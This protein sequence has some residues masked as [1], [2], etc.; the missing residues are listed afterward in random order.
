MDTMFWIWLAIILITAIIE[1]CT[2]ELV[3]IWFT[4]GSIP[5]MILCATTDIAIAWQIVIGIIL[6]AILIASFRKLSI[7]FLFR[8]TN[9]KTNTDALIGQRFRLLES[10]NFETVGKVK[11]KDIEWS[12]V[13]NEGQSISKGSIVEVVGISGTKLQVKKA[14]KANIDTPPADTNNTNNTNK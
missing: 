6:S 8:N 7:K 12:V 10:T 14:P 9:H 3:S 4:I 1:I 2:T 5:P 13:G 11:V